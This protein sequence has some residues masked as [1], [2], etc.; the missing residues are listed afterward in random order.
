MTRL[1]IYNEILPALRPY[2]AVYPSS[3]LNM[4]TVSNLKNIYVIKILSYKR[5]RYH[6]TFKDIIHLCFALSWEKL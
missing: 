2:F 1:G 3:P 5:K 4:D 6:I